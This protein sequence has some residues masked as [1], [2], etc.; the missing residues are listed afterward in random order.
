M[1]REFRILQA[2]KGILR[3][4]TIISIPFPIMRPISSLSHGTYQLQ[5]Q[6]SKT[7]R[8]RPQDVS[9]T[10]LYNWTEI[11]CT[12]S[13]TQPALHDVHDPQQSCRHQ[14]IQSSSKAATRVP[15][16][17]IGYSRSVSKTRYCR[18]PSSQGQ[19]ENGMFFLPAPYLRLPWMP[20]GHSWWSNL[21]LSSSDMT[22]V[23]SFNFN[24][25]TSVHH[26]HA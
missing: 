19:C 7:I 3:Y 4:H 2:I 13:K 9:Q 22:T 6:F 16:D 12:A 21:T 8:L 14:R 24:I 23:Y 5:C 10:C 25:E 18:T 17:N 15:E 11:P 1:L 26:H 20:S